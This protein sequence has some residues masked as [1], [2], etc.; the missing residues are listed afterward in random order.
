MES[1]NVMTERKQFPQIVS[2]VFNQ[3][4]AIH[5]AWMDAIAE[6]V[7]VHANGGMIDFDSAVS[8]NN[9]AAKAEVEIRNGIA[10]VPIMGTIM[11]RASLF[12]R[13]SGAQSYGQIQD[14]F[15]A[16]MESDA[17]II[18]LQFDSP[19]GEAA[20]TQETA[21][22]IYQA[23]HQSDKT[24][25]AFSDNY[26][27]SA[28]YWLASQT[29]E[30]ITTP[31]AMGIGSIGVVAK[32]SD[33]SRMERNIGM[34]SHVIRSGENKAVGQGPVTDRQL[35]IVRGMVA[36]VFDSFVSSVERGRGMTLS[37]E[38]KD[39][40]IYSGKGA[41]KVGLVDANMTLDQLIQKYGNG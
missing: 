5:P 20:G 19:G 25:L 29:N 31:D 15:K 28:A 38:N 7:S 21:D 33:T 2:L 1:K 13:I 8:R 22:M 23:A 24:I 27:A 14:N 40:R 18:C 37:A 39:G 36:E 41:M 3:P 17:K 9:A 32:Y 12:S 4:W 34:D 11:R 35:E 10:F 30:I 26:M 6:I 16:A